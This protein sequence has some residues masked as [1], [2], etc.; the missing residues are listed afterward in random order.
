M[1][2]AAWHGPDFDDGNTG[3]LPIMGPTTFFARIPIESGQAFTLTYL[4]LAVAGTPVTACSSCDSGLTV[5]E[6]SGSGSGTA[7][8]AESLILTGLVPTDLAGIPVADPRFISGS[9][10]RY[11]TRGVVP[12]PSSLLLL[13]TGLAFAA[14]KL[15]RVNGGS[16]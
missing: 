12:E 13:G 1:F 5:F 9:G 6:A 16:R 10:T 7:N 8:F 11:G 3:V 4:L 14:R 2:F 15:R